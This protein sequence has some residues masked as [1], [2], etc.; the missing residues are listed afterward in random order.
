MTHSEFRRRPETGK[1]KNSPD[2][3]QMHPGTKPLV[4]GQTPHIPG[5]F[6]I[7]GQIV[8]HHMMTTPRHARLTQW[9][10]GGSKTGTFWYL[11]RETSGDLGTRYQPGTSILTR[12]DHHQ[13]MK[14][15]NK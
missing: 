15:T 3:P 11:I 8:P 12:N 7:K 1:H 6:P 13:P 2:A 10:P 9:G 14:G 4:R 5:K